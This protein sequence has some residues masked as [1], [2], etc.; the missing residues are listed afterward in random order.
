MVGAIEQRAS[1][2]VLYYGA[3]NGEGLKMLSFAGFAS[4]PGQEEE[5]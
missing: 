1:R 4:E 3:N 5:Q 2:R